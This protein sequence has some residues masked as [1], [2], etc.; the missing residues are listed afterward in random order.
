MLTLDKVLRPAPDVVTRESG[1]E[2][3]VVAPA[4]GKYLVLN[5]TGAAIFKQL[6]GQTSLQ[7]IAENLS[8][9]YQV[10]FEQAGTDVLALVTQLLER[11]LLQEV[12][13]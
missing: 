4:Q 3:V 11:A 13:A 1:Q 10:P 12:V 7:A 6:N 2:L 8:Q 5:A 9:T